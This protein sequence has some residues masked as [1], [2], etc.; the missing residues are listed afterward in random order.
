MTLTAPPGRRATTGDSDRDGEGAGER[1]AERS[2]VRATDGAYRLPWPATVATMGMVVIVA[3]LAAITGPLGLGARAVLLD[4]VDHLPGVAVTSGLTEQQSVILW[5]WRLPRVVLGGLV[6]SALALSGATYQGVFR[7]PLADPYLLGV[8][9]GAG[10]GATVAIVTGFRFGW[11]PLD[12]L[13]AASFCGALVGVT[14]SAL[15]GRG[16]GSSPASLLLAGVAVAAFLTA[17][18]TYLMQRNSETLREVYAWI[19]GRLSTAGWGEVWLLGPYVIVCGSVIL[20]HRRHL[21]VM[22]LGDDEAISVGVDPV[23]VRVGLVVAASLLAAAAVA[24]SG[25]ISFVGIIVPHLVRLAVGTSFRIILPLSALGGAALLMGA[26][27]VARVV[28][29]PAELPIGVVTAFC[30][31]PFFGV[32]LWSSKRSLG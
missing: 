27:L 17:I 5:Q 6:G 11:G 9:A 31:A 14:A 12:T 26:D 21:D 16:A 20:L 30:G 10:L 24:V 1:P 4:L 22:R 23:R 28:A 2:T 25:L 7:N 29:S 15:L 13:A 18:Q 3:L 32:V 19:L 8:A